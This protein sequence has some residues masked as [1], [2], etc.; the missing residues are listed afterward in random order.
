MRQKPAKNPMQKLPKNP[1]KIPLGQKS[2][3]GAKI[4]YDYLNKKPAK[5]P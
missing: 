2:F 3:V 4:F 1:I 5:N